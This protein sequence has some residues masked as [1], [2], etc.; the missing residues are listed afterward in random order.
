MHRL[1]EYSQDHADLVTIFLAANKETKYDEYLRIQSLRRLLKIARTRTIREEKVISFL[2]K[3]ADEDT[4]IPIWD[5]DIQNKIREG[6]LKNLKLWAHFYEHCFKRHLE[7]GK[8][9]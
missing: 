6:K 2:M 9:L 3:I 1:L 5:E 7:K 8:Y 4:Y